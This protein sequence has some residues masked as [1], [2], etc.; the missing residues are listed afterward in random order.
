VARSKTPLLSIEGLM[1]AELF[2]EQESSEAGC[3]NAARKEAGLKWWS[4]RDGVRISFANVDLA[5]DD[6]AGEGAWTGV[7]SDAGFFAEE[8]EE[9]GVGEDLRVGNGSLDGGQSLE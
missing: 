6:L 9:F 4:E 1:I 7:E 3:E 8:A 2:G 5:L